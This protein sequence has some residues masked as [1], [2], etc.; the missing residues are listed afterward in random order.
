MRA[1]PPSPAWDMS[2]Y[3]GHKLP[4]YHGHK[5]VIQRSPLPRAS[6]CLRRTNKLPRVILLLGVL[7]LII[8]LRLEYLSW[9]HAAP[10]GE[11]EPQYLSDLDLGADKGL[12]QLGAE[13]HHG[14]C[15]YRII[16]WNVW[17]IRIRKSLPR[18]SLSHIFAFQIIEINITT[19]IFSII[20]I[21][22]NYWTD[23]RP[24]STIDK[25]HFLKMNLSIP[26]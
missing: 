19:T 12:P 21:C 13:H 20:K 16:F 7:I 8:F 24:R 14:T 6:L 22:L 26:G 18:K 5:P 4:D 15:M 10:P 1:K 11:L 25:S 9:G 23:I 2:G 3:Y 17:F